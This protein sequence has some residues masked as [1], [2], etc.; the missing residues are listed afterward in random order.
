MYAN[1][2]P[3][4][5]LYDKCIEISVLD[6]EDVVYID[7]EGLDVNSSQFRIQVFLAYAFSVDELFNQIAERP[8]FT[9]H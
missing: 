7:F 5:F 2:R 6:N 4:Q 8:M 3:C 9:S 1:G